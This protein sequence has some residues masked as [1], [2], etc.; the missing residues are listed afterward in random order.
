VSVKDASAQRQIGLLLFDGVDELDTVGPWAVL[1]YGTRINCDDGRGMSCLSAG[2]AEVIG[3]KNLVRAPIT[4]LRTH[5]PRR[6]SAP[7]GR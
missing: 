7:R 1:A 4:P 2:G 5:P 6:S 3:A